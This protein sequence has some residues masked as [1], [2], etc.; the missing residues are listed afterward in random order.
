MA[1][2]HAAI[3]DAVVGVE[4]GYQP[5]RFDDRAPAGTSATAAA[6]AAAHKILETYSPYA[7]S[8]LDAAL[9]ASLA[10]IPDGTAKADGVAFGERMAQGCGSRAPGT[11]WHRR[12]T[13]LARTT[14][15]VEGRTR[16]GL[17]TGGDRRL[18]QIMRADER[19]AWRGLAAC[20][21]SDHFVRSE[22]HDR[23]GR[24]LCSARAP[25]NANSLPAADKR[26]LRDSPASG[27]RDSGRTATS[28]RDR[29]AQD[30]VWFPGVAVRGRPHGLA[31]ARVRPDAKVTGAAE[32]LL[33]EHRQLTWA[34]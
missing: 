29:A 25:G 15:Q 18:G 11:L 26:C 12:L 20:P 31:L 19:C 30:P 33:D 5:Y 34:P 4:G 9:A 24:D 21:A 6:A 27:R 23:R 32:E 7:Q 2:L 13:L 14:V 16:A 8:A 17:S 1:F 10:G 28:C 22:R 3:Y